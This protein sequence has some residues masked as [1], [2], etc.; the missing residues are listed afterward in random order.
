MLPGL[1]AKARTSL[2]HRLQTLPK[3]TS[4]SAVPV[5]ALGVTHP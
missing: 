2:V 5:G 4:D 1:L 3:R